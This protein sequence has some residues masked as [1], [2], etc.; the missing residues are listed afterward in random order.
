MRP[1]I[2]KVQLKPVWE[3]SDRSDTHW[4][5]SEKEIWD[6]INSVDEFWSRCDSQEENGHDN[7]GK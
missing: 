6:I 1:E 4:L 5:L 2:E 3:W 7:T